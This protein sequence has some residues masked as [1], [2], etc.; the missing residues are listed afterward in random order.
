MRLLLLAIVFLCGCAF[1]PSELEV[2]QDFFEQVVDASLVP[3]PDASLPPPPDASVP[4]MWTYRGSPTSSCTQGPP[5]PFAPV[6]YGMCSCTR[7]E[8]TCTDSSCVNGSTTSMS[9]GGTT[10]MTVGSPF[11]S[12]CSAGTAAWCDTYCATACGGQATCSRVM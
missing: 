10:W 1:E 6:H 3:M 2:D 9:C 11:S 7:I 4:S 8:K 12:G 5:G